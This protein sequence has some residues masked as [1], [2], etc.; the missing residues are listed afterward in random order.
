MT[1]RPDDTRIRLLRDDERESFLALLGEWE[2]PPPWQGRAGDLF[3]RYV[4]R[5]PTFDARNVVVAERDRRLVSCVQIFPR[6]LRARRTG[7]P[8][9]DFAH[10]P[11]G[12]IGSVFTRSEARGSGV[13]S[14][15]LERARTEMRGRGLELG[16]LVTQRHRFYG[17]LG[18]L[19]WPRE[20]SLWRRNGDPARR[21]PARTIEPFDAAKHLDEAFALHQAYSGAI[22]G[23][24]VR[25]RNFFRAQLDF[26]GN[27]DEEFVLARD[28]AG[29]LSA[30]ARGAV[31]DGAYCVTEV[32]RCDDTEGGDALAD[33]V[34]ALMQARDPDPLASP[35]R[36]SQALRGLLV[37][38]C[39]S[40]GAL[41]AA[42]DERG[43]VRSQFPSKDVMLCILE[44][45]ALAKRLGEERRPDDDDAGWLARALPPE[46]L[47]WWP[48]DR[49]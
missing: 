9:T 12:G 26:A 3:R 8:A 40:D 15:L 47:T 19:L 37:A 14:A 28:G 27:P 39:I 4:E 7:A 49:F 41:D 20:R 33:L 6:T 48:A 34:V 29:R 21:A 46:R 16:I 17:R 45:A 10:V 24:C 22:A 13:G 44:P 36:P 1:A 25:D 18:W 32:A 35:G 42:L 38:P 30:Y 23:T 5:D 11:I 2:M 43:V 31:F